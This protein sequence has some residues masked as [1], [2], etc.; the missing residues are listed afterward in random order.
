MAK[1]FRNRSTQRFQAT[2]TRRDQMNVKR[3]NQTLQRM[4]HGFYEFDDDD[5]EMEEILTST[6]GD[7]T[8]ENDW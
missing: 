5:D 4:R 7:W 6:Y 1:T 2:M 8:A 3:A